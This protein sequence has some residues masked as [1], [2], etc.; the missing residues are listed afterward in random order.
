MGKALSKTV[1][2]VA[3]VMCRGNCDLAIDKYEY[4]GVSD[5]LAANKLSG[6]QKAC[7]FGCLGH[8]TCV[9]VCKFDAICI[10]NGIAYIDHEKCTGCGM[11]AKVCPKNV[12][13]LVPKNRKVTVLC[14]SEDSGK[15]V[16]SVCKG[17]CIAC[18]ICAKNCESGAI[19][20]EN[21]L[22]LIDYEKCVECGICADKCPKGVIKVR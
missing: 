4:H 2:K 14:K 13:E 1:E 19:S 22:A 12:I 20:I 7:S 15:E 3:I 18:R 8:G 16:N 21:N 9:N 5:C 10:E 17:G 11:C 6:G